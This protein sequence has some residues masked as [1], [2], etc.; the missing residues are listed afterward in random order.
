M[1]DI[2][3]PGKPRTVSDEDVE[4]VITKTLVSMPR[5]AM[6]LEYTQDG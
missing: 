6:Q 2:P 1:F 4:K 5:D 3:R